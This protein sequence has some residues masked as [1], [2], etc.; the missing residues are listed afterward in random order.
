M[1]ARQRRQDRRRVIRREG[2]RADAFPAKCPITGRPYFMTLDHP[3]L[4]MVPTYGGP[5]DSYTIPHAEGEA[6]QPWH[7]REL[8]QH[9]YD[10]DAGG[11][12]L[13]VVETIPLR[14]IHDDVRDRLED[15]EET[16]KALGYVYAGNRW[17]RAAGVALP[18]ALN[19]KPVTGA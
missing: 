8:V 19:D 6:S 9:R 4:G 18:R 11:W 17:T 12:L 5:Y 13:D 14:I 1:N 15:A 16:L 2:V 7:E 10:H 3:E